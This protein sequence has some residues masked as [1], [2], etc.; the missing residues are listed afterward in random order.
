MDYTMLKGEMFTSFNDLST[1]WYIYNQIYISSES[2]LH[3]KYSNL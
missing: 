2:F 1:I 3:V